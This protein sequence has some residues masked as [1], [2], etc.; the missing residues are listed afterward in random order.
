VR[1]IAARVTDAQRRQAKSGRGDARHLARVFPVEKCAILHLPGLW[2]CFIPEKLE[3]AF[4]DFIQQLFVG[5][6]KRGAA[7]ILRHRGSRAPAGY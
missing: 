5:P 7:G 6:L 3:A 2:I 4:L 1:C